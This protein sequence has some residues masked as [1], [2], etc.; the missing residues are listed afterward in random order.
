MTKPSLDNY[1]REKDFTIN[2]RFGLDYSKEENR[3]QITEM[4]IN[5]MDLAP[6][7]NKIIGR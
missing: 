5:F 1:C 3:D 6:A 4:A 7:I 2:L